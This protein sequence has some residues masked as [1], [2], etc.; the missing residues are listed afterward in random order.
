M[1]SIP[2][3]ANSAHPDMMPMTAGADEAPILVFD[4]GVGGLSVVAHLKALL[5]DSVLAYACDNAA[6]P[7]GTKPDE[8]LIKRIVNVCQQAVLQSGAKA[9]VVACNTAS[10]LALDEL[11]AVL[12]IPVVG[13][14]PAIKPAAVLSRSKVIGL[15]ATSAT[16]KRAYT[17]N[18]ID[19]FASEA[20]VIKISGD[21]LVLQ[22]ERW[23]AGQAPDL[24]DI[25]SAIAPLFDDPALDTVV[26]GCT[27]FPLLRAYFEQLAPRRI[28]W[29]DSGAAIAQRT[30]SVISGVTPLAS[31]AMASS[32]L[33]H[34]LHTIVSPTMAVEMARHMDS[35]GGGENDAGPDIFPDAPVSYGEFQ[36]ETC[37]E[38]ASNIPADISLAA[39][40]TADHALPGFLSFA[41]DPE[42][43]GLAD[44]LERYRFTHPRIIECH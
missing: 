22:A 15:L 14:V 21:P 34:P 32:S 5:P 3:S 24:A 37:R 31:A 33:S 19:R 18:L 6:L 20:R 13:T 30:A 39:L 42:R 7:Y 29:V 17:D 28:Q 38:K 8:W 1:S 9:L 36:H 40:E 12:D 41:T 43:A 26:L 23:L 25:Q 2:L 44:A 10:T 11:R 35:G 4:S 27:H 16:L